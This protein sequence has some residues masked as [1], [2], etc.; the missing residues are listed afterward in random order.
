MES[1]DWA[2][3]SATE[4]IEEDEVTKYLIVIIPFL[5]LKTLLPWPVSKIWD[6]SM[7]PN[8]QVGAPNLDVSICLTLLCIRHTNLSLTTICQEKPIYF[9][10]IYLY[11]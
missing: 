8:S 1:Q 11:F 3:E 6:K 5:P 9:I 10:T 2:G 4:I 7:S